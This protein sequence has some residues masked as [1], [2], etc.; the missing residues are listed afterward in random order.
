VHQVVGFHMITLGIS[1]FPTRHKYLLGL[2]QNHIERILAG[3]VDELGVS[4]ATGGSCSPATPHTCI[5]R[6]VDRASTSVCRMR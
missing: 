2:W 4:T 3:W 1:D 6:W 5:P